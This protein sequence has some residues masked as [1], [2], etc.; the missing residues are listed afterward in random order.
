MCMFVSVSKKN[1]FSPNLFCLFFKNLFLVYFAVPTSDTAHVAI[2][3][4]HIPMAIFIINFFFALWAAFKSA[5]PSLLKHLLLA[6]MISPHLHC[7]HSNLDYHNLLLHHCNCILN[8]LPTSTLV[9]LKSILP[10]QLR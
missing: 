2:N 1:I 5:I 8:N 4:L 9:P 6:F 3:I 10:Q 7:H